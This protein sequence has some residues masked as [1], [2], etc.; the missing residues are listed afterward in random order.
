MA[1]S[2][3]GIDIGRSSVRGV[4]VGS[5]GKAKPMVLR[6]FEVPLPQGAVSS[7]EVLEPN[8]VAAA[9]RHLWSA[10]G[11]KSRNVVLGMGN[12]RVLA[13][14]LT[15]PKMSLERIRQSLPFEVQ[16]MLPVPVAEAVLDFYPITETVGE[17]GPMV[18]G[19]LLA[20]VK[21]AVLANVKATQLAG[22]TAIDVDLIP[23]ALSRV[24]LSR[25]GVAGTVALIDIGGSTTSV[26]IA[27]DGVPQFVRIIAT[28]GDDITQALRET[29]GNE[30][31]DED[32]EA[33]KR[34]LG[35][36]TGSVAAADKTAVEIVYKVASEQLS[37]LRNTINYFVNTRPT[38]A[39]S[40]IVLSGG[41]AQLNGLSSALA[42]LTRLSVAVGDPFSSVALARNVDPEDIR[43]HSVALTVALGLALGCAA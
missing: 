26:V 35:L 6:Y 14:D 31:E 34:R 32:P 20:A 17:H 36:A 43:R 19:L 11:F 28:G 33:V 23:F 7:G 16:D 3:V 38:D 22:L 41:G 37:S 4:E 12:Q 5:P 29:L 42:D 24:L 21:K 40:G 1:T 30:D 2:V 8:T 18:R 9:L 25:P 15:V 39:V 10:G 27:T 13:R